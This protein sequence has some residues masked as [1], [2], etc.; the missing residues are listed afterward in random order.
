MRGDKLSPGAHKEAGIGRLGFGRG[1]RMLKRKR[2]S[3][4]EIM[5]EITGPLS[6]ETTNEFH[7]HLVEVAE[8][9]C[10]LVYLNLT[11]VS[12][13]NSSS[14]GKILLFRKKLAEEGKELKIK[15]CS[16]ALFKTFQ[17]IKFD[18]LIPIDR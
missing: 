18:K 7:R 12:A 9:K 14:L 5:I 1:M 13:I 2:L 8:E 17:M 6:G 11:E 3:D 4:N 15:G 16:D 10:G